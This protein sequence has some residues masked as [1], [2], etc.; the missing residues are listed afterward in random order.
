MEPSAW[1]RAGGAAFARETLV[2][3][4]VCFVRQCLVEIL[5]QAP[6]VRVCGEAAS[7]DRAVDVARATR[8]SIVVLDAAFP[9]GPESARAIS[10]AANEAS[11]IALGI[12]ETEQDVLAWAE[13]GAAGYVPDTASV[14]DL[15]ALIGQISRGEQACPSNIAGSLL[16]RVATTSRT[17]AADPTGPTLTKREIEICV[18]SARVCPTRTSPGGCGSAWARPSP[19][20]T[21]CSASSA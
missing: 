10:S 20:S 13:A 3:S 11:L 8:P 14:D 19:M 15:I 17:R 6:E 21:I 18:F 1:R 16:R 12:R 9:G 2:V 4:A 5:G 7:L